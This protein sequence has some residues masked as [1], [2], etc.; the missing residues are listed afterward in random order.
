MALYIF[1]ES[2]IKP[3]LKRVR[4]GYYIGLVNIFKNVLWKKKKAI[5]FFDGFIYFSRKWYKTLLKTG[6]VW[7]QCPVA[8]DP[9]R[10]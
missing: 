4:F 8:L 2:G 9:L 5:D 7:V 10:L 1:H 6:E 3:Y